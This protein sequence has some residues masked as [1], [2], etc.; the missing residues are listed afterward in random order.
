MRMLQ[1]MNAVTYVEELMP[2]ITEALSSGQS[3]RFFPRGTS[4]MP[5]LRQDVDSVV[6]SPV[7]ERLQKYDLAFYQRDNGKYILHRIVAAGE[8]YTCMGDN[9]TTPESG[10]RH[11]QMLAVVTGFYRNK[12]YIAVDAFGYRLY[13]NIWVGLMPVR[14]LFCRAKNK[15]RCILRRIRKS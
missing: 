11:D 6:L 9:Q 15:L 12:R 10:L 5:M 1:N 2:L 4:M 14:R 3:V 7:P 8:T 13:R